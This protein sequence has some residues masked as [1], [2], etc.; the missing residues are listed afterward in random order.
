M[1]DAKPQPARWEPEFVAICSDRPVVILNVEDRHR[2]SAGNFN[3]VRGRQNL[4]YLDEG[5]KSAAGNKVFPMIQ[6]WGERGM[7]SGIFAPTSD[8]DDSL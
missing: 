7:E 8:G 2:L 1:S 4:A 6:G 3:L 5:F